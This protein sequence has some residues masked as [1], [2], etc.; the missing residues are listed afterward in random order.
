MNPTLNCFQNY[1]VFEKRDKEMK[2]PVKN[3]NIV[4]QTRSKPELV[5]SSLPAVG[6]TGDFR[7]TDRPIGNLGRQ[8]RLF[9][10][11]PGRGTFQRLNFSV[12]CRLMI[13]SRAGFF[14]S[15]CFNWVRW[16][17][18]NTKKLHADYST[19][20]RK[21]YL[22]I[23]KFDLVRR[24]QYDDCSLR[25]ISLNFFSY[26][27]RKSFTEKRIFLCHAKTVPSLMNST[28]SHTSS[29]VPHV[30]PSVT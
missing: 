11:R 21:N 14:D 7:L 8:T 4:E 5:I 25:L 2:G 16:I 26:K 27:G 22:Q 17:F 6:K 9:Q 18:S 24:F 1:P 23:F 12:A 20:E 10:R 13:S 30:D 3:S 15:F 29:N 19:T 28:H